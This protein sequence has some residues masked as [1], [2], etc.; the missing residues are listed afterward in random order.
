MTAP[1]DGLVIRLAGPDDLLMVLA[2]HARRDPGTDVPTSPSPRQV[3]TWA[4]VVGRAGLTTYLALGIEAVAAVVVGVALIRAV[5]A[6]GRG[7][8]T[9]EEIRLAFPATRIRV[10]DRGLR[11]GT[12]QRAEYD[13]ALDTI[14]SACIELESRK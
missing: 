3:E 8:R 12:E 11:E 13:R 1:L 14:V 2:V 9:K 7:Q 4:E 5:V 10:A 6:Y